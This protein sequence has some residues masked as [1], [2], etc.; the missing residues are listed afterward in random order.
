MLDWIKELFSP[1]RKA[2]P[3][4]GEL[5]YLRDAKFWE[6]KINFQPLQKEVEILIDGEPAG[7]SEQQK[8]FYKTIESRYDHLWP[9]VDDKLKSE[10]DAV[11]LEKIN[12]FELVCISIP[13]D[14]NANSF[15]LS[16]EANP[17]SWHF[18][19]TIENWS[20]KGIV[21]EC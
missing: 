13:Q 4:L 21:A 6:G 11:K 2:D 9:N 7:P 14:P 16:Y 17:E 8:Q 5:R 15:E 1:I 12:S 20:V 18:T 10:A 3:L 19:V